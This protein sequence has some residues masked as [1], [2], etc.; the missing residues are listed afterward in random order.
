MFMKPTSQLQSQFASS[1]IISGR[2]AV[3]HYGLCSFDSNVECLECDEIANRNL[4]PYFNNLIFVNESEPE[5]IVLGD[6]GV[7]YASL[8]KAIVD[9]FDNAYDD[10]AI[11]EIFD[12]MSDEQF[13]S[14]K[15]Y[16]EIKN[17]TSFDNGDIRINTIINEAM[18]NHISESN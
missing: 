11:D 5:D 4:N 9:Y 6:S 3:S 15:K 1:Y 17:V 14:F 10:S 13:K 16:L 2:N 18:K 8:N 12:S 7:R